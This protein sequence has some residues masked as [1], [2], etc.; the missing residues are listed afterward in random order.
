MCA[1]KV[2]A[3]LTWVSKDGC[4]QQVCVVF[5]PAHIVKKRLKLLK[6]NSKIADLTKYAIFNQK[7]TFIQKLLAH[8]PKEYKPK[9]S[10]FNPKFPN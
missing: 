7:Y 5:V 2:I 3:D 1:S 10:K 9:D 6:K 4:R 8:L